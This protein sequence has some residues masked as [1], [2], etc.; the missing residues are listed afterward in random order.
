[1]VCPLSVNI[2]A[3]AV[4]QLPLP[5]IPKVIFL[6]FITFIDEKQLPPFHTSNHLSC[7]NNKV[8]VQSE[9][10]FL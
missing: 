1:M 10:S 6:S 5:S 7:L 2:F 8:P 9:N 3:I 4:P